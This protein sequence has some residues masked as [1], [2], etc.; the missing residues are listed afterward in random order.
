LQFE[1]LTESFP[2]YVSKG[3]LEEIN[4]ASSNY[5]S[6]NVFILSAIAEKLEKERNNNEK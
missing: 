4:R 2:V 3:L 6:R 1:R 5:K